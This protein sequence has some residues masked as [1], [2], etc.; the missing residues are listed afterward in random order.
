MVQ[1]KSPGKMSS[2][3]EE[4]EGYFYDHEYDDDGSG[5]EDVVNDS[6]LMLFWSGYFRMG[7]ECGDHASLVMKAGEIL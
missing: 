5:L 2:D 7:D 1:G 3:G 6:E 4:D